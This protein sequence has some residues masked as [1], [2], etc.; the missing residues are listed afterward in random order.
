MIHNGAHFVVYDLFNRMLTII[1]VPYLCTIIVDIL[2]AAYMLFRP[3]EWVSEVMQLTFMSDGFRSWLI[4]LAFGIFLLAWI[5]EKNLFPRVAQI[6]G[7]A[8]ARLQP[9]YR[10]K[11][12]MYKVLLEEMRM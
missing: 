3:S 12:R 6:L 9:G 10:K 2:I 5:S 4:A 7:V 11:R 1:S 8:R